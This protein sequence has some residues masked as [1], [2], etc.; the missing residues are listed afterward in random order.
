MLAAIDG[1][2]CDLAGN[3][4]CDE[5]L[6]YDEQ[7][8]A[9]DLSAPREALE[10]GKIKDYVGEAKAELEAS[11]ARHRTLDEEGESNG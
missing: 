9:L 2:D 5:P 7:R 4:L 6:R 3:V 11:K 10:V 1:Q 8:E